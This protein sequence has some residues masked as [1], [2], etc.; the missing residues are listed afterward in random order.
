MVAR[1]LFKYNRLGKITMLSAALL[2]SAATSSIDA[3]DLNNKELV[4]KESAKNANIQEAQ[5]LNGEAPAASKDKNAPAQRDSLGGASALSDTKNKHDAKETASVVN[6]VPGVKVKSADLEPPTAPPIKGFHPIKKLLRPVENLEG[7]TVKLEQQIMKLEGPIA[8]LQPPMIN[9]QKKM[10]KVDD[11]LGQME[12]R[13]GGMSSQVSG[14]R[15]DIANMR[16]DIQELKTPIQQLR[17]PIGTVAKPLEAVQNQLSLIL[18]A[19]L[20]AAAAV[21]IGTPVAAVMIYRNRHKLFP[22]MSDR[23]MPKVVEPGKE[24]A[25]ARR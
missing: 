25:S 12:G 15:E 4:D 7:M 3:K 20:V 13:L 21:A 1:E 19:I 2:F 16:K 11:H 23:E 9:L 10:N 24:P 5:K 6:Q 22:G 8:A 18:L 17:G 14:V